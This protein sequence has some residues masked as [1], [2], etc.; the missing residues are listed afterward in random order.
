MKTNILSI[1][2][3]ENETENII[4]LGISLKQAI[5]RGKMLNYLPHKTLAMLFERASTRTRVSFEVG[6]TLLGGHALFLNKEDIKIGERE[7]VED[8]ALVLSRYVDVIM[9]RALK[10]EDLHELAR[11]ATVPVINGLDVDEHPCQILADLMTIKEHKETLQGLEFVF[12]GDGNDNLTHSYMLGC[13][14]VGMNVT[15]ISHKNHWPSERFVKKANEIAKKQKVTITITD[16]LAAVQGADVVA[17][18]TWI[19]L[20]YEK[21]RAQ[22]MADLKGYTVTKD[23][24]SKAKKDAI[25][26][27]CMPIYYGEEVVKEVAHG[28]QSVIIDEA[29]NRM[30]AQMALLIKVLRPDVSPKMIT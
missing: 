10:K 25:F 16:D 21:Q 14:M 27:H 22:I 19:S 6:M 12:V 2:D 20:W 3:T 5:R 9:Y 30:W 28:P 17:T 7:S 18:D 13:T 24:M 8:I 29:E 23:V 4:D 26:M 1:M 11:H 15:V